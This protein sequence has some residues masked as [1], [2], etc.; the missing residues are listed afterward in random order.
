MMVWEG[1][2]WGDPPPPSLDG[3]S[4]IARI[5]VYRSS[6]AQHVTPSFEFVLSEVLSVEERE[7]VRNE[8][9]L[10]LPSQRHKCERRR[11]FEEESGTGVD[12]V[13]P[14]YEEGA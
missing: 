3:P 8:K 9:A 5:R 12:T 1:K 6:E 4:G 7:N 2:G 10:G 11:Q 14:P 13:G